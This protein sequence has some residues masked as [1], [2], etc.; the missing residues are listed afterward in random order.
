MAKKKKSK[1]NY[2]IGYKKPPEEC[3]WKKGCK[4]PNPKGRPKKITSIKEA[5]QVNLGKEI[6]SKNE[7]GETCKISCADAL[8]KK[9]LADAIQ[10]D[11]PTRRML[12]RL[13]LMNLQAKEQEFEYDENQENL[14]KFEKKYQ[15]FIKTWANTPDNLT[16]IATKI[17]SEI[18]RNQINKQAYDN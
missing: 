3:K 4:S 5:L 10:K 1:S 18:L 15:D 7:N 9:T 17:F 2:K 12:Y 6:S 16:E 11:G 8:V 14:I 13:D